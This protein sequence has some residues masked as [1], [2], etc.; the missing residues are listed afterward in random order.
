MIHGKD[1]HGHTFSAADKYDVIT[2]GT[3]MLRR[4]F[5]KAGLEAHPLQLTTGDVITKGAIHN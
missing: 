3:D 2:N 5:G 1:M 4:T